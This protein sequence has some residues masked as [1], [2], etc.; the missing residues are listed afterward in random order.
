MARLTFDVGD[1]L[2]SYSELKGFESDGKTDFNRIADV[3]GSKN[4]DVV[5]GI[6]RAL[7]S[8]RVTR[9]QSDRLNRLVAK[10]KANS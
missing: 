4:P 6:Y 5:W 3:V 10:A 9:A 8:P 1:V 2:S 7:T